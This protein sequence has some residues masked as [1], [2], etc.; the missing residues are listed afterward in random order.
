MYVVL[1][2][3]M[4]QP[5]SA[6]VLSP[7]G[8]GSWGDQG[9]FGVVRDMT[10]LVESGTACD[11]PGCSVIL[12]RFEPVLLRAMSRGYVKDH[13]GHYV[14][15]GL[16]NGF[17]LGVSKESVI[18]HMGRR[19]F[20]NYPPA[21]EHRNGITDALMARVAKGKT[22]DLGPY[23]ATK[24]ALES[25]DDL[26][27]FPMGCVLKPHTTD[28][29]RPTSD[30]SKT[31][32]NAHTVMGILGH[33]LDTYKR[34][35]WLLSKNRFMYVSDVEDAFMLIPLAP[36]VW[37][38]YM[39]RGFPSYSA[40]AEHLFMHLFADFGSRG[41]PGTF[42]LLLVDCIIQ[43]ARSE[44]VVTVDMVIHVDD[45]AAVGDDEQLLNWE[46][47]GLQLWTLFVCGVAWKL[48]KDRRAARRQL[49]CGLWWDSTDLTVSLMESKREIYLADFLDAASASVLTLVRRQ[50]LAGRMQRAVLT[51]PKGASCLLVSCYHGMKNLSLPWHRSRT[52]KT[53]RGFYLIVHD[54]L[55]LNL[56]R[57]HYRYDDF[58]RAPPIL[59]DAC[60]SKALTAGG[61]VCA[62]GDYD[63]F[64]YGTSAARKP[65]DEIE[66]DTSLR[67]CAANA[68][69]WF[70]CVV[71]FGLDNMSYK[72]AA[73]KGRA[74]VVRLN[75]LCIQSFIY[76]VKFNFIF[77]PF[78]LSS[79][80]NLSADLLSRFNE[81]KFLAVIWHSGILQSGCDE[82]HRHPDAGRTVTFD[83]GLPSTDMRVL[84]Q[85]LQEYSSN[86]DLD[87]S[88][89][90]R[91]S[92]SLAGIA[93]QVSISYPPSSIWDGLP[94]DEVERVEEVLDHRLR[95]NSRRRVMT[96]YRSWNRHCE[97]H[98]WNPLLL[99]GM[100]HRGGRMVSWI[101]MLTDD[102][103][104]CYKSIVTYVWG[105]RT[106]QVLQHQADPA[107]GVMF[108]REFMMGVSVLTA[109][110]S[111]PRKAIPLDDLEA[112]LG[113][114]DRAD[115]KDVNLGLLLLVSLLTFS[116]TE[117]P[118]PKTWDGEDNFD[119]KFHWQAKDFKLRKG[120]G[121]HWVLWVR[122]KAYKQDGRLERP[123][124]ADCQWVPFEHEDDDFGRDW[125]PLG[126]VPGTNFSVADWYM[127]HAR[128]LG[129]VQQPDEPM[130]LA[131]DTVRPYT[132]ACYM[133]DFRKALK[134]VGA[135][136]KLGPHCLRVTG[137]NLSKAGNGLDLTVAHG[138]WESSGHTRYERFSFI[139]ALSISARMVGAAPVFETGAVRT[140]PKGSTSRGKPPAGPSA[141]PTAF[142]D[143][144]VQPASGS[145]D[146]D[147]DDDDDDLVE[148]GVLSRELD[149][150]APEG[151][152]REIRVSATG[153]RYSYW[154]APD[155]QKFPS[156]A[157]CWTYVKENGA[158]VPPAPQGRT[159]FEEV[160]DGA[161]LSPPV[162]SPVFPLPRPLTREYE[163]T[164][165]GNPNCK[166]LS[167][168][169]NH[170]GL[171][172]FE[173]PP[174]R[175]PSTTL[176]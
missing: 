63:F 22:L 173:V 71:P 144:D 140:L 116:R 49:F 59:S 25:V 120:P 76:Q 83:C 104:V 78:W 54:L 159:A 156:R 106:W 23:E 146:D 95:P 53:E 118:C 36:W 44:F 130:F 99:T 8:G 114:L 123:T 143:G 66:G 127:A 102:T 115:F 65:I 20:R 100:T 38:F 121:G 145:D 157:A 19:V 117:C 58:K 148:P 50:S 48:A 55:Q 89:G 105:M 34:A 40:T 27:V 41:A 94:M 151:Y 175:R 91:S 74:K 30:H 98:G 172:V 3:T 147:D 126:D 142:N 165:C 108:W 154:F 60:K 9:V 10:A 111:E 31:G 75:R 134:A 103:A 133:A 43:M 29:W 42:K 167:R 26:C 21:F 162:F 150:E 90:S 28:Q 138:G 70:K 33:T 96:A 160:A 13:V 15:D 149:L 37:W 84:R 163:P 107:F 82:L 125:I 112:V 128:T 73:E 18:G 24:T 52:S 155:G 51:F 81:E 92:G 171:C 14:L 161:P 137:Y 80:D 57:G 47:R 129:R 141:K 119:P 93:Q 86:V 122:F 39:C 170:P 109:V 87:G 1:I 139:Q 166:V 131:Q 77:E 158:V 72:G 61:W 46:M 88:G 169:G 174:T 62:D 5:R 85:C 16:I 2:A 101:M 17:T 124:A 56:G 6:T 69:K 64:K 110:P 135:D 35:S 79:E 132:Y 153:R 67:A 113:N 164:Q 97:L 11:L 152:E 12:E 136:V 4:I 168:N 7:S 68:H 176:F 45:V 32:W